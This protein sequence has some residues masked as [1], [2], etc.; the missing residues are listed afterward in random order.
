MDN[1][2]IKFNIE[3]ELYNI[4]KK[5]ESLKLKPLEI[6]LEVN[7]Y[8]IQ[9]ELSKL[10]LICDNLI[11]KTKLTAQNLKSVNNLQTGSDSNKNDSSP[12]LSNDY[13]AQ[14]VSDARN[15]YKEINEENNKY[16]ESEKE[17]IKVQNN[18]KA[19]AIALSTA[20]SA[21]LSGIVSAGIGLAINLAI[22]MAIK[23]I[24]SLI[25]TLEE[26]KQKVREAQEAYLIIKSEIENINSELEFTNNRVNELQ[27]KDK[28]S[29]VEKDE[30]TR[31]QQINYELERRKAFLEH[32]EKKNANEVNDEVKK[33]YDMEFGG[34]ISIYSEDGVMNSKD[35]SYEEY[36]KLSIERY[37]E[38]DNLGAKRT[39][40]E[41]NEF[42]N[43]KD[44]II[45]TGTKYH[46]LSNKLINDGSYE[47]ETLKKS[48]SDL[49]DLAFKATSPDSWNT[50]QIN[51]LLSSDFSNIKEE[52]L[53]LSNAGKLD[54]STLSKYSDFK[55]KLDSLGISA[56]KAV[57]SI[58][59]ITNTQFKISPDQAIKE[60]IDE[61]Q[62]F[63][64]KIKTLQSAYQSLNNG[65]K[66]SLNNI[67]QL[68]DKYPEY[69]SALLK[70][71]ENRED[72]IS[73]VKKLFE[74]E[75]Q[76][77]I[78]NL[79]TIKAK[80]G[81]EKELIRVKKK[82]QD[83][84]NP[85]LLNLDAGKFK[86]KSEAQKYID[87]K[88]AELEYEKKV[89]NNQDL[90]EAEDAVKNIE[91]L[92]AS[93]IGLSITDNKPSN[94][95]KGN[96]AKNKD[97]TLKN[98]FQEEYNSLKEQRSNDII[99][100]QQYYDK[101]KKL[102]NDYF[103]NKPDYA[104]EYQQY[105]L[106]LHR[107]SQDLA[108]EKIKDWEFNLQLKINAV[109]EEETVDAQIKVY[110]QIQ[111]ELH[112]LAEEERNRKVGKNEELIQKYSEQW[113]Q[114]EQK[115]FSI[116]K[117][118]YDK[119]KSMY[120]GYIST[121]E[122][123]QDMTISMI[124]KEMEMNKELHAEKI[125]SIN[126]EFD[127]KRSLLDD[128][129]DEYTYNKELQG[130][131]DNV[132][133]IQSQ[134][135]LIKNDDSNKGKLKQLEDELKNATTELDDFQY[136][137]NI[138][139]QKEILDKE[140]QLLVEK[141]Q[142][143]ID[144]IN[145]KLNNE[146]YLKEQA[147]KKIKSSGQN[148][149]NELIAFSEKYGTISKHEID[150]IWIKYSA[151]IDKFDIKQNGV[152]ATLGTLYNQ[153]LDIK[154]VLEEIDNMSLGDFSSSKY[155]KPRTKEDVIAEM[156][157]NSKAWHETSN[158]KIRLD[159]EDKNINLAAE[160]EKIL[161]DAGIISQKDSLIRSSN[162]EL[163]SKLTGVRYYHNGGIV[164][165][166]IIGNKL[167]PNELH[168]ILEEGELVISK[169]GV[170]N[171]LENIVPIKNI[172]TLGLPNY[173]YTPL[174]NLLSSIN[175]TSSAGDIVIENNYNI[176]GTTSEELL[177]NMQQMVDKNSNYTIKKIA[178][179]AKNNS[180]NKINTIYKY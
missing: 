9:N 76:E 74:I 164:D 54:E 136:N 107:L 42:N 20:K 146:V 92:Q 117:Q 58:N 1:L 7:T 118:Y 116:T 160:L 132:N 126:D 84:I 139:L 130:K 175:C 129:L 43:L 25:V 113:W 124:K 106:E 135:D 22:D 170:K 102:N 50:N 86:Y 11:E 70:I 66:I 49:A 159:L 46:D 100:A 144:A 6:K 71:N 180:G 57:S 137:H 96:N 10:Q 62:T 2:K 48:W 45:E 13:F 61:V 12:Y 150:E 8:N 168:S 156:K 149:Y 68:I 173:N 77:A 24:D 105:E 93:L 174:S 162:G 21:L 17:V 53:G 81:A 171:L 72:G 27:S 148:L 94:I 85:H 63:S 158:E 134:I 138:D 78:D 37:K 133:K 23:G 177:N 163:R 161:K 95:N 88:I 4:K 41:E 141:H 19:S 143:E 122:K 34:P 38:L 30:L 3:D 65:E 29:L 80:I 39:K 127:L 155:S 28:L 166:K 5:I 69:S 178:E 67:S 120:E 44:Y 91:K 128:E 125:K 151:I 115:K 109:G 152:T 52:L 40:V 103:A 111:D 104:D 56:D 89:K 26:Q 176:T 172:G 179:L 101:L 18:S 83:N 140:E 108:E 60:S 121:I 64:D 59:D 167:K 51:K 31:L 142:A 36:Y 147:D 32:E 131:I 169:N 73:L 114:Y 90:K 87:N 157:A 154:T 119:Q 82:T 145:E 98:K 123:I 97:D 14:V 153:L 165:K 79:N 55:S 15:K 112:K 35:V 99:N 33:E 16:I 110:T 47:I 75:K